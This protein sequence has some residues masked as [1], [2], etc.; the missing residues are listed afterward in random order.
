ME[1]PAHGRADGWLTPRRF[2]GLLALFVVAAFP[3]VVFG[4]KSFVHRDFG[5]FGH[6]LAHYHR[7]CFWRGELPL[8]NPYNNLGLP[9]L[10]QWNTMTL[11]PGSLI[12]LLFP[13]PWSLNIFCLVHLW[14]AGVGMFWLAERWTGNRTAAAVAGVAFAFNGLTLNAL[15]W[16][17]NIAALGW[18]PWV[19]GCAELA[20][21]KGGRSLAAAALVAT[22]QMLTG[23]PE[24][25]LFTWVVVGAFWAA[26]WF[27]ATQPRAELLGRF[28]GLV[29]LVVALS[30]AQLLPFLDLM[31]HSHRDTAFATGAWAMPSWGWLNFLV[32]QFHV[33][34]S[35]SGLLYQPEQFWTSSHYAGAAVLALAL[36]AAGR[37]RQPRAFPLTLL[38]LA[39]LV[40]SLGDGGK[41]Y[42]WIREAVP[43]ANFMRFPI[44]FVV[45]AMF[46]LPLLAAMAVAEWSE[47]GRDGSAASMKGLRWLAVA[48]VALC[49]GIVLWAK[50]KPLGE[51]D[52]ERTAW[53]AGRSVL[54][55]VLSLGLLALRAAGRGRL[56]GSGGLMVLMA[57]LWLDV[58][59]HAPDQN[60]TAPSA[61][62]K[63]GEASAPAVVLGEGR[64]M[65][66]LAAMEF[67]YRTNTTEAAE[68]YLLRRR[69]LHQNVNLVERLP[70]VDGFYSLYLPEERRVHF[71]L[72]RSEQEIR[73]GL[74]DFIGV[75]Q[76]TSRTNLLDWSIRPTALPWVT[77]G[78]QP[79]FADATTALTNL[80]APGFDP[81][82]VV[83]L[84]PEARRLAVA[85]NG[86]QVRVL[87][88][89]WSAQRVGVEV[90][91]DGPGWLVFAQA[92][93]HPWRALV[94]G[95][96][97]SIWQA[98][99]AFQ[100]VETP[101]GRHV[102]ELI[103]RDDVFRFGCAV[104]L[105][106]L[107]LA[108]L[109]WR[110]P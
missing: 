65:L 35:G 3:D 16:P 107:V 85:T 66:S 84:P 101:L 19:V 94:D 43:V 89:D 55:I 109:W 110:K 37:L 102:V 53:S 26:A 70:K 72:Y 4:L 11:Y 93:Y 76:I 31:R 52:F 50:Q 64:A 2:A 86:G 6:P 92:H 8:W 108:G 75:R 36:W 83:F 38:L 78:Q 87:K 22:L 14:W 21:R 5:L 59:T 18:M 29:A 103:Y 56:S 106:G 95:V 104:S 69:G 54:F 73:E 60:P 79:A 67:F 81:R 68:N 80:I 10:A 34:Q 91:S 49:G 23:A 71:R 51:G 39:S 15:M 1:A 28:A 57:L 82:R 99:V 90:E 48:L 40:L 62:L 105:A 7:E 100:A 13:L 44:K 32:P 24:I 42:L 63:P 12:Y 45:V 17:N 41:I 58:R 77:G 96:E 33:I 9:F 74:A 61:V 97:V 25:I 27:K 20:W 46:A 88:T 30:A 47:R 98:N